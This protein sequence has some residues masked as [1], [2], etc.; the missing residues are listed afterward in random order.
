ML[1]N[2]TFSLILTCFSYRDTTV[3]PNIHGIASLMPLLFAPF[4][5]YRYVCHTC[6]LFPLPS[7]QRRHFHSN[8]RPSI[9]YLT[10]SLSENRKQLT[11]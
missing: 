1:S 7:F 11:L 4:A 9:S 10:D 5:E 6:I 8:F 3:M 2:E